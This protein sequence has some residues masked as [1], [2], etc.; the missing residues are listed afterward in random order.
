M[1]HWAFLLQTPSHAFSPAVCVF[2]FCLL[3]TVFLRST[4]LSSFL[5]QTQVLLTGDHIF[6]F[7]SPSSVAIEYKTLLEASSG[8]LALDKYNESESVCA[9]VLT[10][11]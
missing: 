5:K 6:C 7:S 8:E 2:A 9:S 10:D 1:I 4:F 3:I 11:G